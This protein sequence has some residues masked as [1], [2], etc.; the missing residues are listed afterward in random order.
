MST[1]PQT[2]VPDGGKRALTAPRSKGRFLDQSGYWR[3]RVA[4]DENPIRLRSAS[5]ER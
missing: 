5:C 4:R 2:M 3:V 1:L